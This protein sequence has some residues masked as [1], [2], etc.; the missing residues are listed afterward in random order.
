MLAGVV[1]NNYQPFSELAVD[2]TGIGANVFSQLE[3]GERNTAIG[4]GA[5]AVDTQQ[6][7]YIVNNTAIGYNALH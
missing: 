6:T 4:S 5:M 1:L 2:N 3:R 7:L